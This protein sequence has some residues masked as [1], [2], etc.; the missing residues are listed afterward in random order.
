[1]YDTIKIY[2][3]FN[4][5]TF[6]DNGK[7]QIDN[8]PL[9]IPMLHNGLEY[10]ASNLNEHQATVLSAIFDNLTEWINYS[11]G[12]T[13]TYSPL[14]MTILGKGGTGK[15]F[16]I[17]TIV[18]EIQK[19]FKLNNTVVVTAPTGAAAYNVRGQTIHREFGVV[20]NTSK[21][22]SEE[23]KKILISNLKHIVVLRVGYI[24]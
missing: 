19:H 10:S 24:P 8:T 11:N 22:I 15:S 4:Q 13:S 3:K 21:E 7:Q 14:R 12:K 6:L 2:E 18:S 17:N 9:D 20:K 23:M 1:M 16:L 5:T